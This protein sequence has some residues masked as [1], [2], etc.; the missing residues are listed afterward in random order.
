M[1]D[2]GIAI[3]TWLQLDSITEI[4]GTFK[5]N[6]IPSILAANFTLG[7][8]F[9]NNDPNRIYI[10]HLVAGFD[11]Q[12]GPGI[13]VRVGAGTSAGTGGGSAHPEIPII[14]P[15]LQLTAWADK[16]NYILARKV[17]RA[18]YDWMQRA[19]NIELGTDTGG[20]HIGFI[21]SCQEQVEGQD[22]DDPHTGFAT[23]ISFWK[24]QM[25]EQ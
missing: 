21:M 18:A 3:R 17:Y 22:F 4:D 19:V 14:M 1:I 25:R 23:N 5:Q 12:Y 20:E 9:P 6:Q 24:I 7:G 11:A 8:E 16:E 10:G 15:R 2:V 13:V